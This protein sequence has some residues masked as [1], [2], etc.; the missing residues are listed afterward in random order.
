MRVYELAGTRVLEA[1]DAV[2]DDRAA[3]DLI[4]LTLSHQAKLIAVPVGLLPDG[5]FRLDTRI[6]GAIVQKF[7]QYRVPVAF[8]GDIAEHLAV[9]SA[10][11]AFV[12]ETNQGRQVWFVAGDTE[13]ADRLRAQRNPADD[14]SPLDTVES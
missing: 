8:V 13:L 2:P 7:T 3:V 9:S 12:H 11:R 4:A 1:G 10:L 5:F 14:G 6:A